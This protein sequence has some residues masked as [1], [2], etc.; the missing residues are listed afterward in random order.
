MIAF[1]GWQF[2]RFARSTPRRP[3]LNVTKFGHRVCSRSLKAQNANALILESPWE[4]I[5]N[6]ELVPTPSQMAFIKAGF[7]QRLRPLDL[8]SRV[9]TLR[10]GSLALR[11]RGI[12]WL[13]RVWRA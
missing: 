1:S 3:S 13:D 12:S 11:Q 7:L 9:E 2:R 4:H 10:G 5:V 6:C 8:I